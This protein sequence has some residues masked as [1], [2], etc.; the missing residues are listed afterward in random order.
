MKLANN[1]VVAHRGAWKNNRLPENSIAA[2]KAAIS[3]GCA[4]SETDVHMTADS[5]LVINHDNEWNG[6]T[7][8]KNNLTD[9]RKKNLSNGEPL[10]LLQDFLST[11]THQKI[12]KLILEIK[13]SVQ[14]QE[15]SNATVQKTIA[16]VKKMNAEPWIIYISFDYEMLKEVLRLEPS[17]NTQYL[18]GD[19]TPEQ[20]K[21]D[22][23][24]GADY[25]YSVFKK[26]PE[27]IASA[28]EN[29]IDLDAWTVNEEKDMN[30][31]LE[32]RFNFITT[33]KPELLFK[34]TKQPAV[35]KK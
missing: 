26:H 21:A 32:N 15:W 29:N 23:I 34:I 28:K 11:I 22:G 16:L 10:P 2:L 1:K 19:K 9:L 27:W 25:H 33:N 24:K 30:W 6:L 8:Q 18:N 7:I 31:L 12:T 13:P 14:G 5:A 35:D 20:L 3:Q 4:G 17:A